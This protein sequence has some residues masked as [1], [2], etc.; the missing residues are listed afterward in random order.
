MTRP[1]P[2]CQ[3]GDIEHDIVPTDQPGI[4]VCRTCSDEYLIDPEPSDY[5][6]VYGWG[7]VA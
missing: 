7:E 5:D 4:E 2:A 1:L 3:A 6:G